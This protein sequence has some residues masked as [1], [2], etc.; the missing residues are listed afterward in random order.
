VFCRNERVV[1]RTTL[2]G[3]GEL[4]TLVAVGAVLVSSVRLR[5]L[6]TPLD[7]GYRGA[8]R[9]ACDNG[10]RKGEELG[11]FQH[12]STIIVLVPAELELCPEAGEGSVIRMGRPLFRRL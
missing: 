3:S 7:H 11:F 2:D 6:D 10:F 5:F 12:G 1:L 9:I 8:A 4:V